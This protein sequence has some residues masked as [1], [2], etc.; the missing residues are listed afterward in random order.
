MCKY[1]YCFDRC[2]GSVKT[3][4]VIVAMGP[5]I[6][7]TGTKYGFSGV[8]QAHIIDATNKLGGKPVLIPRIG[9]NDKRQRH[10][11]I[12]H[13]TITVLELCN[14]S[15]VLTF[16]TMEEEKKNNK[17]ADKFKSCIFAI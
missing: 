13:H 4:V 15:C 10:Q 1:L 7:G 6:V 5:G 8:E 17:G 11:G 3:D 16:P 12:S 14:S 9:F 2:K